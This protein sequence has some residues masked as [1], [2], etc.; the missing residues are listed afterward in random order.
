MSNGVDPRK[1]PVDMQVRTG[2]LPASLL[3]CL[4]CLPTLVAGSKM[5]GRVLEEQLA[6]S[7]RS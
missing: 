2:S 7:W 3:A 1:V 4:P 5:F 6:G